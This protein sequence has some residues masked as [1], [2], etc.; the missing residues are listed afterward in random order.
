V[1]YLH[2]NLADPVGV[3]IPAIIE[4]AGI[5]TEAIAQCN[6]YQYIRG[7]IGAGYMRQAYSAMDVLL[8]CTRG[9][10]FGLPIIEAQACGTPAI[11][12]DCTAMSELSHWRVP[13]D[14]DDKFLIQDSYQW[15]P[16]VSLIAEELEK[17]YGLSC[18][19]RGAFG[20]AARARALKYD[21]DL[22]AA[23]YW[24]PALETIAANIKQDE[25]NSQPVIIEAV[26]SE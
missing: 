21:A 7:M 11:V 16:K 25:V 17:F 12:T 26:G 22:V 23:E 8:N 2:T 3:N 4:M 15:I 20:K 18:S 13:V 6:Q 5:P 9:E 1:L 19:D 24:K 14:E 10:G